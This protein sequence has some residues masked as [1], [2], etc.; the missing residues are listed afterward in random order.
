MAL[1]YILG[2]N[3]MTGILIGGNFHR[4]EVA[5]AMSPMSETVHMSQVWA[6]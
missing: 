5:V 4:V 1:V 6:S 3:Y 2:D